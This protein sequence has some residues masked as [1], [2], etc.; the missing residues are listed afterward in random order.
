MEGS[1]RFGGS[2]DG[3]KSTKSVLGQVPFGYIELISTTAP[4]SCY[5][6][7]NKLSELSPSM[8]SHVGL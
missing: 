4:S 6:M 7:M 2:G 1:I 5:T 8:A 3:C